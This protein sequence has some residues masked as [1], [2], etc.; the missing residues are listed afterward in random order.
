MW[1]CAPELDSLGHTDVLRQSH[2]RPALR[3]VPDD[4]PAQMRLDV[5]RL[6]NPIDDLTPPDTDQQN[7]HD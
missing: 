5:N 7:R 3:P 4:H 1:Q 2:E 6:A